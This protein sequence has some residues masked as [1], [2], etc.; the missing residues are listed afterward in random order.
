M[1]KAKGTNLR[2]VTMMVLDEADKM[3]EMGFE[4]QVSSILENVRPDRQ[5]L[6]FSATF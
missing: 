1:V 4:K 2:R 3:L 5:T 6:M